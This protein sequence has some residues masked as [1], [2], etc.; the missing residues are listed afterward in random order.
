MPRTAD[1]F[2][3]ATSSWFTASSGVAISSSAWNA[4]LADIIAE[5][6]RS[7]C[8]DGSGTMSGQLKAATT[9]GAGAPDYSFNGD[10]DTGMRRNA[11]NDIRFAAGG[12]DVAGVKSAPNAL[13]QIVGGTIYSLG[14]RFAEYSRT[15]ALTWSTASST[16][17][18][19]MNASFTASNVVDDTTANWSANTST[20]VITISAT[21]A[22]TYRVSYDL[23]TRFTV[24]AGATTITSTT[25]V[26]VNSTVQTRSQRSAQSIKTVLPTTEEEVPGPDRLLLS[27]SNLYTL[28]AGDTVQLGYACTFPDDGFTNLSKVQRYSLLLEKVG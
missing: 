16:T 24:G 13:Y 12:A 11:A 5:I 9:G 2:T 22:G 1:T 14:L 26:L 20:G 21:G 18:V 27:S 17:P 6:S 25:A 10:T 19:A 4:L 15:S 23:E 3:P 7:F 28:V 8:R